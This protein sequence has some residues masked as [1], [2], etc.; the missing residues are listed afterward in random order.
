MSVWVTKVEKKKE[1]LEAAEAQGKQEDKEASFPW[2]FDT[3][4]IKVVAGICLARSR[5]NANPCLLIGWDLQGEAG[6]F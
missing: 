5:D 3:D 2:H 1:E 6:S 4:R